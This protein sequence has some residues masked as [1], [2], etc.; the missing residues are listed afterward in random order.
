MELGGSR[1]EGNSSRSIETGPEVSGAPTVR[2]R[3]P[4]SRDRDRERWGTHGLDSSVSVFGRC[5]PY[6]DAGGQH[7][8]QKKTWGTRLERSL[9]LYV[10]PPGGTFLRLK[11]S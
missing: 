1:S 6:G 9:V 8:N 3:I 7:R 5:E 11:I 10:M 2:S 4:K